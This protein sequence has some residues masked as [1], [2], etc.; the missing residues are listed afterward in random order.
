MLQE[1]LGKR[2]KPV[3]AQILLGRSRLHSARQLRARALC[4]CDSHSQPQNLP[5]PGEVDLLQSQTRGQVGGRLGKE[6]S[7]LKKWAVGYLQPL[8]PIQEMGQLRLPTFTV[9]TADREQSF[10]R[11]PLCSENTEVAGTDTPTLGAVLEPQVPNLPCHELE[12]LCWPRRQRRLN[13][14]FQIPLVLLHD[15]GGV[16]KTG[17]RGNLQVEASAL[18]WGRERSVSSI[19][20]VTAG[21]RRAWAAWAGPTSNN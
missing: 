14:L 9:P 17:H 19:E 7:H 21:K 5:L 3:L 13:Q 15:S 1:A 18:R 8:P 20:V 2:Q 6:K 10:W 12:R 4:R 11:Q 16:V